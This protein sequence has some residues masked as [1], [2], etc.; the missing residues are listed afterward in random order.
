MEVDALQLGYLRFDRP[1][2]TDF[3]ITAERCIACG[4]CVTNCPNQ[5]LLMKDKEGERILSLCGTT[6]NRLKLEYCEQCGEVVGPVRYHD[7]IARRVKGITP[8]V[9]G[10]TVCMKCARKAAAGKHADT[11]PPV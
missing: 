11:V 8:L 6:L 10:H 2:P 5:A 4:A 1:T 7:Y 3:R 9:E